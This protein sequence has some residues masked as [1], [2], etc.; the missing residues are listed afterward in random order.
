MSGTLFDSF[1]HSFLSGLG[2]GLEA[3]HTYKQQLS[4]VEIMECDMTFRIKKTSL[5]GGQICEIPF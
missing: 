1:G 4:F 3:T 5:E 2:F